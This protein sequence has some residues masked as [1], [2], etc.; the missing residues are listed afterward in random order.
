VTYYG[1]Y[2]WFEQVV[3]FKYRKFESALP[4][5]MS[6]HYSWQR[7]FAAKYWIRNFIV[8]MFF[9]YYAANVAFMVPFYA[10]GG[11]IDKNGKMVDMWAVGMMIY[12]LCVFFTHSLFVIFVRNWDRSML[13]FTAVIWVQWI[14]LFIIVHAGVK[15]DPLYKSMVEMIFDVHF[16]SVL[17]V[18]IAL[19][20]FPLVIYRFSS[21]LIVFNKFNFA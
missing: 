5:K 16:W 4:F 11:T 20:V 8:F 13:I 9:A 21:S 15:T 6:Q 12:V 19:M 2:N 7:D 14:I 3:S 17:F 1:F 18:T 10:F